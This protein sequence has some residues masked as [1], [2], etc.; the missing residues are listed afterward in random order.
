VLGMSCRANISMAI[1]DRIRRLGFLLDRTREAGVAADYFAR[2][3]VKAASLDAPVQSLSGGNQQKIVI[4]KWLARGGRL[5]IVDEPTR[6]VDVGAKAAIHQLIDELARD[7][8]A[9]ILISSELP[10]VINLSTRILVMREGRIAGELARADF[11]QD[12]VLRLMTGV[13]RAAA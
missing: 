10:E 13:V 2:L 6:G 11:S 7:G 8:L 9:V 3:N 5:L 1:L 12:A 4:A